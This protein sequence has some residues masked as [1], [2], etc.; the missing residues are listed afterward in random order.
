[1]PCSQ[2][3]STT[4]IHT[5]KQSE[6]TQHSEFHTT[7]EKKARKQNQETEKTSEKWR[8]LGKESPE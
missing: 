6:Q 8:V 5:K 2:S 3:N 4:Y 7:V 1:M